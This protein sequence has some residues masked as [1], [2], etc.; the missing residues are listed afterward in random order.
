MAHF[1][2]INLTPPFIVT[3]FKFV[4]AALA[5]T[6][7]IFS[8][9]A[10]FAQTAMPPRFTP[11]IEEFV[12]NFKPGGQDFTGQAVSRQAEETARQLKPAQ[13]YKVELVASEPVIRQPIDLRFDER[14]RLWVVQYLQYPFPAGLTVTSYDQYLRADFNRLS[15]PPPHH[16]RGA[17][18]ITILEDKDGDGVFETHKTFVDGLNMA[19][20]VLPGNGGVWVLMSPYLLFYPDRNGDDIPDGDPEV[21]LTGFGLEDTHSLASNLHWGP[22]GW[23]YGAK[24]STT[25]L[26]IQGVRLLGQGIWRYH[27][28]TKVFEVFAEGGGNTFSFEFDKYG[29]AFSGTNNGATRGLHYV[30]GGTYVK[31]WTKHGPAMNPFIFGFF[32]HMAHEGY[33]QRFPQAFML[34]EGGAMP[35]LEGQIVVG[36]AMTNRVQA[37]KVLPDTSSFRTVDSVALVTTEEKAFRPVD[38]EQGPDGAIYIADWADLRLSHLNPKDTWDKTNGRI[39]RIV[40]QNF[41]RPAAMDL[42]TMATAEL[43]KLLGHPNREMRENARRLLGTRPEPIGPSLRAMVERNGADALEA[44]WV[45]NLRGELDEAGLRSALAHPGEHVRRWAVRLLGDRGVVSGATLAELQALAARE[46]AVE[47]RSQLASSAKRLPAPQALALVRPLL[48]HDED[49]GDR[50]IPLLLWWAIE[51][52]ADSG[53]EELLALVRDPAV[54]QTKLFSAHIAERIGMRYTA[55]QGP[56]KY[57]HLKQGVYSDWLIERAPEYLARNLDMCGRLLASAPDAIRAAFLLEGMAKGLTGAGVDSVPRN[58]KEEIARLWAREPHSSALVTLAAR[59]GWKEAMAEAIAATKSGKLKEADL[60]RYVDLFAATGPTEALPLIA[61]MVRTEKN[62]PRRAKRLAALN[63][64]DTTAAAEVI[65]EV[66]PTLTPRLQNTAQRMLSEKPAWSLAMLQ[67]MNEGTFNPGIL[68]S[69]NVELIRGHKDP[70]L[71]SLLTSFQQRHSDDP[72]QKMAQQLFEAGKTAYNLSCAPCHQESGG[73]LVA[74]AP[75][76]VG[77]RWLQRGDELLVRILL[78]GKENPG[79]GLVM[80]SWRQLEDKQIAAILTYVRRE[81]GNQ[82]E[83]VSPSTVAEV[84]AATTTRQKPWTDAELDGMPAKPR[85][86]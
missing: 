34:Y 30:Q 69:G 77:S 7:A 79:R 9:A 20:S 48:A 63:G 23:I 11:E 76:L 22:D 2:I 37:S 62:E 68:S 71:A 33:S 85:T 84:R 61:D 3:S 81:F 19:T 6:T 83:A 18:R 47:V 42:Q 59:L 36:M 73:G 1:E 15:P 70:R 38:I 50:H 78:H 57:Y 46:T 40:P 56:R 24:G 28:G 65:F 39:F 10:G 60:Q 75:P 64:F 58:L 4:F 41:V 14:G 44:F 67:R 43:V 12:K 51:A 31:G 86:E 66:F 27:P 8:S 35:E 25:N 45:L 32:E 16:F 80:P 72:A 13:G 26:D 29:R 55:D 52:K 5:V 49:A 53:H 74:L 17:D 54:W 82:P 21:H